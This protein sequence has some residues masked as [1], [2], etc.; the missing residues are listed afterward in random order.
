MTEQRP[1]AYVRRPFWHDAFTLPAQPADQPLPKRVD[2]CVVGAGYT[3]MIAALALARGGARVAVLD[4]HEPGWGASTRNGGIF[5]PGLK[6]GRNALIK[7]YGAELGDALFRGGIEAFF[8]GER[9]VTENAVDAD[10]R[11]SGY[12][13]LA[14]SARHLPALR[15][16]LDD[17][18]RAGLT[19]Q[20]VEGPDLG[21]E[22]GTTYYPGALIVEE[23][24]MI[25]PAKYYASVLAAAR[26][27]GVIVLGGTPVSAVEREAADRVVVTDR[28]RVR[29]GAVLV[30][31]NGYTDGAV[32]WLQRRVMPI[33]SY[34][35]ATEPMSEQLARSISPRGRTFF[36]SK[37][38]LYY[39]HVN[40]ERRLIFGG[41]ASFAPTS[42]DRTAAILTRALKLVHP[43]AA[44]LRID[45]AWGGNVGFT[46]DR[47]PHL[48][49]H[50]GIHFALGYCG[51]GLALGT[52]FGLKIAEKIG[53][54]SETAY[55]PSPFER[56][57][58]PGA[59]VVPFVYRG[60]PWFLPLAGE[61][62][63]LADRW[64]RRGTQA[65]A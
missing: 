30:A 28:G 48:G 5:H 61:W 26:A 24:G 4:R 43:Q 63:R 6:W 12:G 41:R 15:D 44:G 55:E 40:A 7:H 65:P 32:P 11:R 23:S 35:V 8:T 57:P 59:P 34:I 22:I 37:N 64:A 27:A 19:A 49:E 18:A 51:S 25:H 20:V 1:T 52:S 62:F 38:F 47:L 33:G 2:I 50:E 60:R 39:W 13:V 42:V 46:F 29:A 17:Y 53:H 14:W 16:E 36:D 3:G 45:Y 58:F 21:H 31:T 54:A 9:F 10:Y 56:I